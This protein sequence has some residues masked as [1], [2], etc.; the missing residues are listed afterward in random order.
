MNPRF[1]ALGFFL[2]AVALTF[3]TPDRAVHVEEDILGSNETGFLILRTESD[4][5]G[6]YYTS[7]TKRYIDEYVKEPKEAG[8]SLALARKERST[9]ILDTRDSHGPDDDQ[10][11]T[12]E[13]ED[14]SVSLAAL[15][16]K[17][18][19]RPR[20]W[21]AE[22]V[23]K[24]GKTGSNQGVYAGRFCVV[25]NYEMVNHVFGLE[26]SEVEWRLDEVAEDMN[27][28]YLKVYTGTGDDDGDKQSRW[29]CNVPQKSEQLHAHL[30]LEPICLVSGQFPT[31]EEAWEK[32]RTIGPKAK[33]AK[34]SLYGLEV[35][36]VSQPT[37]KPVFTLVLRDAAREISVERFERLKQLIGADLAPTTTGHFLE[38][39]KTPVAP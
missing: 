30:N 29:I 36:S 10:S 34:Q 5:L 38:Q 4:N 37:G 32:V 2:A 21:N 19:A 11:Q 35:W 14:L 25:S 8:Y 33:E 12:T 17:Y 9:L 13:A 31:A 26:S 1:L 20:R 18:P 22:Q 16:K 27:C 15:L 24:L 7:R 23:A 39:T 28:V 6:S 3:A